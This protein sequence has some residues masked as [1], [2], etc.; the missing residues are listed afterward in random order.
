MIKRSDRA[1]N[2]DL[3][4]DRWV[5]RTIAWINRYRRLAK[6]HENLNRTAIAFIRLA[7]I[8]LML[9]GLT[10]CCYPS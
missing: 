3:I 6:D 9:R 10:R 2:F 8:S 1:K 5:G 7:S 4:P